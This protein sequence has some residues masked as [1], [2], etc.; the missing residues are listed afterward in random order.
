MSRTRLGQHSGDSGSVLV[1]G[2]VL[3][4]IC[5][6]ALIVVTDVSAVF[7]QRRNLSAIADASA[8]AGAQAID[9]DAYYSRGASEGTTLDPAIVARVVRANIAAIARSDGMT[10]LRLEAVESDGESV[11]VHVSAPIS[12][13]FLGALLGARTHVTASARLDYRPAL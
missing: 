10:N 8:L 13:P 12:V 1:L 9:L 4:A 3:I 5:A 2:I 6:A 11:L 7:L